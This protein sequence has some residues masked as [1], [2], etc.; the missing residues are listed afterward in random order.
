MIDILNHI[1]NIKKLGNP[2]KTLVVTINDIYFPFNIKNTG[3]GN[4]FTEPKNDLDI[5]F[6]DNI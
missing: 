5:T 1:Y 4:K 3:L 2:L 6:Y